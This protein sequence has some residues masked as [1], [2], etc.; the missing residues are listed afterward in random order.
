[1][2]EFLDIVD[3]NGEPTG[4]TVERKKA[5]AEGIRHRTS[6]VWLARKRN[7]RVEILMQKRAENKDSYPGCYDI[8]SAGH[9][10]AGDGF[11]ES[12]VRE[13]QE[14]L[15]VKADESELIYCGDRNVQWDDVFSGKPFH[16]NQFSRIFLLWRDMEEN[17]FTLQREELESVRW[18]LFDECVNGV[19]NNSFKNCIA[20]DELMIL[21]K[22]I[23][24]TK[25]CFR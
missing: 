6:H 18:I 4:K 20:M 10:P 7:G 1:M 22:G 13:L 16:D 25:G 19:L 14:E 2:Q 23:E 21:K 9:I 12:A 11:E 17:Q 15:G 5:H 24:K 3:E 8:S